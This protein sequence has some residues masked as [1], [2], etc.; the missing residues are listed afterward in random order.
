MAKSKP[1]EVC[2]LAG[3]GSRRLGRDKTRLKL[4]RQTLLARARALAAAAGLACRVIRRDAV[5]RSGPLGGVITAL[6][7]TKAAA[8]IFLPVDMP[9]VTAKLLERC[10]DHP[11][12]VVFTQTSRGAGFPFRLDRELLPIAEQQLAG[13]EHSLQSLARKLRARRLRLSAAEAR[14]LFNINTPADWE[15]AREKFHENNSKR[16]EDE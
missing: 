11:G 1:L 2:I 12:R 4:G 16:D 14:Q 10:K 6:R 15:A 8:V 13:G 9:F 5:P 3:G 7:S